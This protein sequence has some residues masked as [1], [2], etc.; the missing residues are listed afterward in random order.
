M[1]K[2]IP[3]LR[4][5]GIG[6]TGA[7]IL[8]CGLPL[9]VGNQLHRRLKND[10]TAKVCKALRDTGIFPDQRPDTVDAESIGDLLNAHDV[11]S[12]HSQCELGR[13]RI[14]AAVLQAAARG[15]KVNASLLEDS[16]AEAIAM[17]EAAGHCEQPPL[18][19]SLSTGCL[20]AAEIL[21]LARNGQLVPRKLLDR[22]LAE[23]PQ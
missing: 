16:A 21:G 15:Q 8:V 13:S 22:L 20:Q 11:K 19:T 18:D 10:A 9:T 12:V 6:I 23:L 3:R 14:A 4:D 1:F 5:I 2:N 17:L 7:A